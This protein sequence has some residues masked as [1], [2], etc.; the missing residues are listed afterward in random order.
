MIYDNI[1]KPKKTGAKKNRKRLG[2][3]AGMQK[4]KEAENEEKKRLKKS[5]KSS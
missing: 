2:R 3:N 5:K 4:K 1:N